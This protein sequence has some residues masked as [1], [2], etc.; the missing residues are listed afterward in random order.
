MDWPLLDGCEATRGYPFLRIGQA[1][2]SGTPDRLESPGYPRLAG[3]IPG[4]EVTVTKPSGG[5]GRINHPSQPGT[6]TRD[7]LVTRAF[8]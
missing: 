3:W 7:R 2:P 1:T 6:G 8:A 4:Y 5:P